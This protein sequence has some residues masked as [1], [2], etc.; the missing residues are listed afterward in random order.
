MYDVII[1]G[2]GISGISAG[3]YAKQAN[4]KFLMLEG[5]MPGGVLNTI[6]EIQNFPGK[7]NIKG[8]DFAMDLFNQVTTAEI[9]YKIDSVK[10]I[11][12]ENDMFKVITSTSEYQTKNVLL[13]TGRKPLLLGLPEEEK[14]LGKGISTCALCDGALYKDKEIVVVGGGSSA[15]QET[16][17]LSSIAKKIT[18]IVKRDKFSAK[19]HLIEELNEKNNVE[20][21]YQD[22]ITNIN[23]ED[24][25][26]V[27]V[28]LK[29][30]KVI[31]TSAIFIYIGFTP[32]NDLVKDFN[33]LNDR[34]Y[35]KVNE[36]YETSIKGLY[37]VGDIIEKEIYQLINAASEGA[38]A[39]SKMNKM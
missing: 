36:N 21:I 26:I 13:A 8:P 24:D 34:G 37:A 22:E 30:D 15:V 11:I 5:R 6:D 4:M 25:K 10:S 2:M 1:I 31:N 28:N 3:L 7:A 17:Y 18:M 23:L 33:V 35:I 39:I 12:K 19:K 20:I 27:S 9:D 38:L 29:S 14:L 16:N 32:S